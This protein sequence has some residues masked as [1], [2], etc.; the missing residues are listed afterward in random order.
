MYSTSK[1]FYIFAKLTLLVI[2]AASIV[3]L[4]PA[5]AAQPTIQ[6]YD[7]PKGSGPHDVAP[8]PDQRHKPHHDF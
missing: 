3:T 7:V 8:A 4:K 5:H 6:E 1:R 2:I